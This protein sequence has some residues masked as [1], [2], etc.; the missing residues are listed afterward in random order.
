MSEQMPSK[1]Y[2][3]ESRP[4][5]PAHPATGVNPLAGQSPATIVR[6]VGF[7]LLPLRVY[8]AIV[9]LYAG[10]SKIADRSFLDDKSLS[11]IHANVAAVRASSPIGSLLGP[12]ESHSLV[13]GV[14]M[15]IGEIAVGLGLALGLFTRIAA[16]GG[17]VL[18]LSLWFTVSW[19][20]SPWFTSADL[21][22]L[23]ALTPLLIGGAGG[24]Y[25][26]DGWLVSAAR[27]HPGLGEDR[28]RRALLGIAGGLGV[29]L[30]LG[31]GAIARGSSK[32]AS[33]DRAADDPTVDPSTSASS[34]PTSDAASSDVAGSAATD[35]SSA[36]TTAPKATPTGAV[37]VATSAVAVGGAKSV[38]DPKTGDPAYVLQLSAGQFSALSA[39]C[40]HQQCEVGFVSA[41]NGF[42]CPCHGSRFAAD[43]KLLEGPATRGLTAIP[44]T[45]TDGSVR[46]A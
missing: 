45:V 41:K 4:A 20:A 9:F 12:V 2:Q 24:V 31:I 5:P 46:R 44:I 40:P 28:S 37:L 33:D 34:A 27:R 7:V 26:L 14:L 11:G 35:P 19:N 8:L 21:V 30:L 6:G 3:D 42:A 18:S 17:M 38:K 39:V 13:F 16:L 36:A 25:S 15:S 23:F 29:L 10:I 43:G 32:P 22:Y 1:A